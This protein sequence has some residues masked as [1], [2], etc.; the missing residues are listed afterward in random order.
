MK[1][2]ILVFLILISLRTDL[3]YSRDKNGVH[4]FSYQ[5]SAEYNKENNL[6][7]VKAILEIECFDN[8]EYIYFMT[9]NLNIN[10][11]KAGS[12][13]IETDLL[14]DKFGNDS[15]G[16]KIDVEKTKQ[17][18]FNLIFYY[19]IQ[20]NDTIKNPEIFY[21]WYPFIYNDLSRWKV[22]FSCDK[23]FAAYGQGFIGTIIDS[24][25]NK[26]QYEFFMNQPIPHFTLI[27]ARKDSYKEKLLS[28]NDIFFDYFF[29]SND[30][31]V[32]NK[33][34]QN[35]CG[36]F[37][38][39]DSLLGKYNY[40]QLTFIEVP[41]YQGVNSQPSFIIMGSMFIDYYDKGLKDWEPHEIAHQWFGSGAF[42]KH[43]ERGNSCVFEPMAEYMKLM[44]FNYSEGEKYF[45]AKMNEYKYEYDTEIYNTA[46]DV[47]VIDGDSKRVVYLK[48]PIILDNLRARLGEENWLNLL[49]DIYT[50]YSGKFFTYKDLLNIIS[51]FDNNNECMK[52]YDEWMNKPGRP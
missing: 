39:Y 2:I 48:G 40:N 25:G 11:I 43:D 6:I 17:T 45:S 38:Y 32:Q 37:R 9:N 26:I 18:R 21:F 47:P 36:A 49:K 46:K 51:K 24:T 14:F 50:N 5:V 23:E 16:I 8:N 4:I 33:I 7:S 3:I 19:D 42:G 22:E 1:K 10:N 15:I 52:F 12:D 20:L 27:L 13:N 34:I 30:T 41:G 35:T 44:Y 31:A 28:V 29:V